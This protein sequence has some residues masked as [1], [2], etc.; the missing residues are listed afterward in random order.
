MKPRKY[1]KVN[2]SDG[3]IKPKLETRIQQCRNRQIERY[4][5]IFNSEERKPYNIQDGFTGFV[6]EIIKICRGGYI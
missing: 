3:Q 5:K 2:Y 6:S 1:D 4:Y